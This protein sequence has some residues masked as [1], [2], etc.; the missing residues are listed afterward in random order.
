M[1][2][3]VG[4]EQGFLTPTGE[5]V[6]LATALFFETAAEI[7]RRVHREIRPRTLLPPIEVEYKQF[8]NA[9]SNVRLTQGR[10]EV[11]ITDLLEGAPAPVTEALA[12]ILLG[13]LYRKPAARQYLHRYRLYLNR[14]DMRRQISL[15]RRTRGRKAQA[16]P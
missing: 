13:K 11:R 4:S 5:G 7:F 6:N 16:G 12:H 10:V 15:V 1:V 2:D 9:D 8:A 3:Q 14:K